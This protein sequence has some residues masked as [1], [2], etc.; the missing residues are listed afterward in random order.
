MEPGAK[1]L[2]VG[3]TLS[4]ATAFVLGFVLTRKRLTLPDV[5]QVLLL[6]AHRVALWEGFML[7]GLTF[8]VILSPLSNRWEIGAAVL[9][10]TATALSVG[11][12]VANWVM[13]VENQFVTGPSPL[14]YYLAATN[15]TLASIGLVILIVGV[16]RGL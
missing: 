14:G 13:R 1:I 5:P 11:S 15:A 3:G 4:L 8:A 16:F 12:T 7:L 6:Q 9:L 10:V 2:I